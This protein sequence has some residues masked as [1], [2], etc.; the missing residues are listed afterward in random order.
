MEDWD[1][2]IK[3]LTVIATNK[4]VSPNKICS[5]VFTAMNE[6]DIDN[7]KQRINHEII[8]QGNSKHKTNLFG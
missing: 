4:R 8:N 1:W 5:Y 2:T 6:E 3:G 7:V